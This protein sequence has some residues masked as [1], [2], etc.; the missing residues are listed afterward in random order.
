[1]LF[2][3]PLKCLLTRCYTEHVNVFL[4]VK[5]IELC[6]KDIVNLVQQFKW[7]RDENSSPTPRKILMVL[8]NPNTFLKLGSFRLS[9]R[10]F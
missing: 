5:P 10:P 4:S 6:F 1:M 2:P 3:L 8:I 7:G 9:V